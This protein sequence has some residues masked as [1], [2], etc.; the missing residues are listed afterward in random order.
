[1]VRG[2]CSQKQSSHVP[3]Y[4]QF[5]KEETRVQVKTWFQRLGHPLYFPE[6]STAISL[7]P[8]KGFERLVETLAG[9]R[10]CMGR[11]REL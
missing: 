8:E 2:L 11:R 9:F 6:C 5:N 4:W 3:N 7:K 1:M 10:L